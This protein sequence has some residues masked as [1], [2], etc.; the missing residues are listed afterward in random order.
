MWQTKRVRKWA[1]IAAVGLL[2]AC[3]QV[4]ELVP[5]STAVPKT[6]E[7]NTPGTTYPSFAQFTDLPMPS[8]ASLD[9]ERSIVFGS[10][11]AWTGRLVLKAGASPAEMYD[12]YLREMPN[13]GWVKVT[14][15]RAGTSILVYDRESRVATI[16][17]LDGTL[18][19][20]EVDVTVS[21]KG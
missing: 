4:A 1:A 9:L 12:F 19:S 10:E 5:N 14:V 16:K 15:V 17:I 18:G 2:S 20:A 3:T 7:G 6:P 11:D 21:P 13:F 8:N